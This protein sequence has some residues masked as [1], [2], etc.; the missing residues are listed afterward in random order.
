MTESKVPKFIE[1]LDNIGEPYVLFNALS[2]KKENLRPLN[3]SE[4]G[5]NMCTFLS[6]TINVTR[7]A[8]GP[9]STDLTARDDVI[10]AIMS[11][12]L[13]LAIEGILTAILLHSRDGNVSNFGFS[14]KQ[15]YELARELRLRYLFKGK[16]RKGSTQP[17][18]RI[19]VKLLLIAS[20]IL[21]FTFGIEVLILF[22]S[23]PQL[24]DVYNTLTAFQLIEVVNPDWNEVRR[25]TGATI[26]RPCTAITFSGVEQ[27]QNQIIACLTVNGTSR[28]FESFEE[29]EDDV[30]VTIVSDMHK[31]GAEH[32]IT[33]GDVIATYAARAY[34]S[35]GDGKPRVMKQRRQVFNGDDTVELMHKQIIAYLFNSYVRETGDKSMNLER[36]TKL[37]FEFEVDYGP[38]I[39]IIQTNGKERFRQVTSTRHTTTVKGKIPR[40]PAAFRYAQATLKASIAITLGDG[41]RYDL[42]M[43]SGNNG[44]QPTLMWRETSRIL[45]WL[46]L[47]IMLV[48]TLILFAILRCTLT[49]IGTAEIASAFV[50]GAVGAELA[51]PPAMMTDA[52]KKDFVLPSDDF[53]ERFIFNYS[54]E[55][56]TDVDDTSMK[57]PGSRVT[58]SAFDFLR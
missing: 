57:E 15:F 31:F 53:Q 19:N 41:A 5:A 37:K 30:S 10:L 52:E 50:M 20:A 44:G 43:G 40:G 56:T 24:T 22:L 4:R 8:T 48:G 23:S 54:E 26:V 18:R 12:L 3:V 11:L 39:N 29:V 13:I 34:F 45:N 33:I 9:F 6:E 16:R 32:N 51:R 7:R 17:R 28:S 49:P 46:S 38:I 55:Y 35:L 47:S 1:L 27:E 14:I 21:L 25:N 58:D 2:I 42:L 36:L